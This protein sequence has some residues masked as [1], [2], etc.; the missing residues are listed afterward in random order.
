V[1][2][3]LNKATFDEFLNLSFN[4]LY[5]IR[6]EL[7]LLLFDWLIIRLDVEAMH[8][9]LKVE[10]RHVFI[11]PSKDIYILFYQ[12]Y[13]VLLLCQRQIFAYKDELRARWI[14]NINLYY[15][16]FSR[17][18]T[19]FKTLLLL[20]IQLLSP[21]ISVEWLSVLF[22]LH[23]A[24]RRHVDEEFLEGTPILTSDFH[25]DES[26]E[27]DSRGLSNSGSDWAN[28]VMYPNPLRVWS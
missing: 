21:R 26:E 16:I 20:K 7:S 5:N 11:A 17:R 10:A 28:G 4:C 23:L 3:L 14:T 27:C 24:G 18:I 12:G 8:S 1:L 9:H 25:S 19:L 22:W 13:K 6:S 2:F 15:C